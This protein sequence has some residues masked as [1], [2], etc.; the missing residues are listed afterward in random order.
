MT[1]QSRLGSRTGRNKI[2]LV[3]SIST[4]RLIV[5]ASRN[6][7]R[8]INLAVRKFEDNISLSALQILLLGHDEIV[9][10]LD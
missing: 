7:G 10:H 3:Q 2:F 5:G 1:R 8:K 9:T 6:F 4:A